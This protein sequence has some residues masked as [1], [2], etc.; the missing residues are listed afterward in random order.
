MNSARLTPRTPIRVMQLVHRF[1]TG[2]REVG[3]T[4]LVNSLDRRRVKSFICSCCPGDSLRDRLSPDIRLHEFDRQEG[5]DLRF[6]AQL[7]ALMRRERPHVVHT[8]GWG[9]LL[10]GMVAAR[11]ARVPIIVHSEHGTLETGRHRASVQRWAW[12]HVDQ[13]VSV[14]S[15]LAERMTRDVG[16]PIERILVIRNGVD[17]EHFHP[18]KRTA[19]RAVLE[20]GDRDLVIG[21]VGRLVPVKDQ[22]T[23]IRALALL[24]DRG[25]TFKAVIAG[26]GPLRQELEELGRSLRLDNVRLLG[27]REDVDLLL[28]GF[29]IFALSSLSEGLS[30]TIQE[31]MATGVPVVATHVGGADELVEHQ[32]NGLLIPKAEPAAMADAI[33]RLARDPEAR[34]S[35]GRAARERAE[36]SF[37]LESMIRSY[38]DLYVDLGAGRTGLCHEASPI[39]A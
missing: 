12:N 25:L 6:V 24:R 8:R 16:Y 13:V 10:E 35:M 17:V 18:R 14:S 28:G 30:N 11:L 29:D 15:R 36:A 20:A 3:M 19:G 22:A 21:S 39:E 34:A 1:G 5:T 32:R 9:T 37:S 2:G 4:K 38:E 23:L 26:A 27:N 31:A 7:Y 33:G